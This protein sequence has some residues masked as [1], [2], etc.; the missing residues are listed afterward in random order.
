M[1][2]IL[3]RLLAIGAGLFTTTA[4]ALTPPGPAQALAEPS[5]PV[6]GPIISGGGNSV[7]CVDHDN[8]IVSA[9]LLDFY[10]AR[11][12]R[13]ERIPK[14]LGG[15]FE[16]YLDQA[17]ARLSK[18]AYGIRT[19]TKAF[20]PGALATLILKNRRFVTD[21]RQM[22][23]F[24][25]VEATVQLPQGCRIRQTVAYL[26]ETDILF[27]QEVWDALSPMDRAGLIMHEV[28]YWFERRLGLATNS[29]RARM[30]TANLFNPDFT[31]ED[32]HDQ[33]PDTLQ[34]FYCM[35]GRD[36]QGDPYFSKASITA[37]ETYY[38]GG[39][40]V[41]HFWWI[42][43]EPVMTKTEGVVPKSQLKPASEKHEF[44]L[45]PSFQEKALLTLTLPK[46]NE[47]KITSAHLEGYRENTYRK[48]F[49]KSH[50]T[51]WPTLL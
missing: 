44:S 9:E 50:L 28:V 1:K 33:K 39:N 46:S 32:V 24:K 30:S 10:E 23:V 35:S 42:D 16:T 12:E 13:G 29:R 7:V 43:G 45:A 38:E 25:D 19:A 20:Y 11:V 49:L 34:G 37:F 4:L 40:L 14:P 2:F 22:P 15:D 21:S 41:F 31:I 27:D 48:E 26:S 51:C 6:A 17:R 3:V 5:R 18:T 36:I 47:G 8:K